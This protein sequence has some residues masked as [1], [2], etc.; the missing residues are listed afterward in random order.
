MTDS[1]QPNKTR[2]PLRENEMRGDSVREGEVR[3]KK[4]RLRKN[5]GSDPMFIDPSQFP[6]DTDL[7]WGP[8]TIIGAPDR[9]RMDYEING[10]EAVKVGDFDGKYDSYMPRGAQGE[11]T[12]GACVLMHRPMELTQEAHEENFR[13]ARAAVAVHESKIKTGQLDGV[14]LDTQHPNAQKNT[15]LTKDRIPSIQVPR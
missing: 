13:A 10:W 9:T 14:S 3:P 4:T 7:M 15:R 2:L 5:T 12:Y 1:N 6:P 11:I 8:N